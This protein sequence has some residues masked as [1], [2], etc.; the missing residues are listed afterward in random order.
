VTITLAAWLIP[1]SVTIVSFA[2]GF[3]WP[4]EKTHNGWWDLSGLVILCRLVI[5]LVVSLAAWFIWALLT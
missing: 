2:A 1:L 3:F 4:V 5:A